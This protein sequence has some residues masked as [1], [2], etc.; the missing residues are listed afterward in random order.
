METAG[1]RDDFRFSPRPN[2]AAE[3][4]W[5]PWQRAAFDRAAAEDKPVLLSI[6]AVWCHWCHVMDETSYSDPAVIAL[7]N[8]RYV[9]IRVDA[10]RRPDVNARYNMGGWPTT[11]VL[12]ADGETITGATYLAPTALCDFLADIASFYRTERALLDAK[13]AENRA[14][15]AHAAAERGTFEPSIVADVVAS[16]EAGY[17]DEYGGFGGEPKF[18][19]ADALEFLLREFRY[20]AAARTG[21]GRLFEMLL[22]T[23]QAMARGGMY[24][25]IEGGFFRYSTTRDWTI[26]HF[27]KMT[28][29][30]GGLLRLYAG[31]VPLSGDGALRETLHST[32]RYIR[33]VL[34]D[35]QTGLFAGSQDADE[36][37]FALSLEAR[38]ARGAPFVDRTSYVNWTC[39][40]AVGLLAAADGL[41][42]DDLGAHAI[43]AIDAVVDA[44][45]IDD[46]GLARH[47][48]ALDGSA[49]VRGLLDDQVWLLRAL[50]DA[51]AYDGASRHRE[52]AIALADAVLA[53]FTGSGGEFIDNAYAAAALGRVRVVAQPIREGGYLADALLRLAAV[54]DDE[55]YA[56]AARAAL[57]ALVPRYRRWGSFAAPFAGAI[58]RA[59]AVAP[60]VTIVG[61][62]DATAALRAAARALPD[63]LTV[64]RAF[65]VDDPLRVAG[66]WPADAPRAYVCVGT[67]CSA[68]AASAA[69]VADAYALLR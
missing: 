36:A 65:A 10:D 68:P 49:H 17:D 31:L 52:R 60:I 41:G 50:L 43:T 42:D 25:H 4:D 28:E 59:C 12:T 51:H 30:H 55:R 22:T 6:S 40:L 38:N 63:P 18:P 26:P 14:A 1:G 24:D 35:P 39:N 2:R 61:P 64:V 57:E 56:A 9:A 58:R 11:A 29:D 5:Q 16:I 44:A 54:A 21:A 37:Y 32:T 27:E 20:A 45:M 48:I 66:G 69:E 62:H 15:T 67:V 8:E 34:R 23:A 47:Y 13:L 33:T 7:V 53:R 3:I 46:D 19:Q